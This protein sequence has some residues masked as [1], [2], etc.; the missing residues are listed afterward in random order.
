MKQILL[1]ARVVSALASITVATNPAVAAL[2]Q[3]ANE[4]PLRVIAKAYLNA[5]STKD[6][7]AM[8]SLW[9]LRSKDVVNRFKSMTEAFT[10]GDSSFSNV[11]ISRINVKGNR[12]TLEVA[13]DLTVRAASGE[14]HGEKFARNLALVREGGAWKI[15]WDVPASQEVADFLKKGSDWKTSASLSLEEQFATALLESTPDDQRSLMDEN[16]EMVTIELRR[17]LIK[18]ADTFQSRGSTA[19][20]IDGYRLALRVAEGLGDKEG[21]ALSHLGMAAVNRAAANLSQALE[22]YQNAL[23]LFLEIGDKPHAAAVWSG[24]GKTHALQ[25]DQTKAVESY[26]KAL[27]IFEELK[28][29]AKVADMMEEI[30]SIYHAQKKYADAIDVLTKCLAINETLGRKAESAVVLRE[31]GNSQ[32]YQENYEGAIAHYLRAVAAFEALA[33]APAIGE[34]MNYLGGASYL[35]ADYDKAI[36]YY[37]KA[38]SCEEGLNDRRG[39]ARSLFGL[40]SSYCAIGDFAAGLDYSYRNL[41]L[42]E[43]LRDKTSMPDTLRL[44]GFAHLRHRNYDSAADA[45]RRCLGLYEESG[46]KLNAGLILIEIGNILYAQRSFD[47]AMDRYRAALGYFSSL[48]KTEGIAASY[49]A[50]AAVYYAMRDYDSALDFYQKSLPLYESLE[51]VEQTALTLQS[52]A[53][54]HYARRDFALSLEFADRSAAIARESKIRQVLW[55]A[56]FTAGSS[57]RALNHADEARQAFEESIAAIEA[58]SA[59]LIEDEQAPAFFKEKSAPYL[60]MVQLLLAQNDTRG[61]FSI[62]ETIKSHTLWDILR[63]ARLRITRGM[64][65]AQ[66]KQERALTKTLASLTRQRERDKQLSTPT[67]SLP[68]EMLRGKRLPAIE[69]RL[70]MTE[71]RLQKT[72]QEYESF[73]KRLYAVHPQ[74]RTL[75]GEAPPLRVEEASRLLDGHT[76][77]LSFTVTETETVLFAL[78]VERPGPKGVKLQAYI[79]SPGRD[80]LAGR[81]A[82]YRNLIEQR[83][84]EAHRSARELYDLLVAPA[85]DQLAGRELL[86]IAPDSVLWDLPFQALEPAE[87][88]Y[89]VE[90]AA[91]DYAPSLTSFRDMSKVLA[92]IPSGRG[93][94]LLAFGRPQLTQETRGRAG[95]LSRELKFDLPAPAEDGLRPLSALYGAQKSFVY[96]G[97]DAT[98]EKMK[99]EDASTLTRSQRHWCA[100][101]QVKTFDSAHE[102]VGESI[103][104]P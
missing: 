102:F 14:T 13:A 78:T 58:M 26:F 37:L 39:A 45:Y 49:G 76:A 95:L 65:A 46:D 34:T 47:L 56:R 83:S 60:A 42:L 50:I 75:R 17:S 7:P 20:A 71:S 64:T 48:A 82:K 22:R 6:L 35:L 92:A 87:N 33:D 101:R 28:D 43:S 84:E 66:V 10:S 54:V 51:A 12:A 8:I 61:A 103:G 3:V 69:A 94:R 67:I 63:G 31:I 73:K 90:N 68:R 91:V 96:A 44:M 85:R 19:K 21:V 59:E 86:V 77:L 23:A 9:S 30:G 57:H 74:L 2:A 24:I 89:L 72:R 41:A 15:W 79:L 81:I 5:Y 53:G 1:C 4:G 11:T 36:E 38:L 62:A 104:D 32:Y 80:D 29:R 88:S 40:G 18:M 16:S 99:G 25:R 93:S 97:A 100:C 55:Q 98:E 27:R 70:Q 52:I